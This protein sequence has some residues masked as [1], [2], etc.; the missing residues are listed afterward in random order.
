MP[1]T[2]LYRGREATPQDKDAVNALLDNGVCLV[3]SFIPSGK[4]KVDIK[5]R[6]EG[7]VVAVDRND[8]VVG[9]CVTSHGFLQALFIDP[10][11][12]VGHVG[13]VL[14]KAAWDHFPKL[15]IAIH[16]EDSE[17][18]KVLDS[19]KFERIKPSQ[20]TSS[21]ER[22]PFILFRYQSNH[23]TADDNS[24]AGTWGILVGKL[25]YI[26]QTTEYFVVRGE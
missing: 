25:R 20:K 4:R 15:L 23:A 12:D 8:K 19:L 9:L 7:P 13:R 21:G 16:E 22:I 18:L 17:R 24:T 6:D 2:S 10:G 1:T 26:Q 3:P 5:I 11:H 14:A